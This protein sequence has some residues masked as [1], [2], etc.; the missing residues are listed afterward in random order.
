[1]ANRDPNCGVIVVNGPDGPLSHPSSTPGRRAGPDPRTPSAR[2]IRLMVA[3][4]L[5][6][7]FGA[8]LYWIVGGSSNGWMIGVGA[9]F[10]GVVVLRAC[11][12][13]RV[14]PRFDR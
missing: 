6:L 5:I 4:W 13:E 10:I 14:P 12:L 1:M 7:T 3:G 2:G 9:A 8:L 11:R